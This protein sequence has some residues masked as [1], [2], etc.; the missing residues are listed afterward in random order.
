MLHIWAAVPRPGELRARPEPYAVNR[1][2]QA[3]FSSRYMRWTGYVVL[4][5]ILYH[6]AQFTVGFAQPATFKALPHY[7][8]TADY[9]ILGFTVVARARRCSTST[10][11]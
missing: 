10:A 5:F 3:T 8:M 2:I 11:W 9:H 4:A 7:T 6:L 1:T